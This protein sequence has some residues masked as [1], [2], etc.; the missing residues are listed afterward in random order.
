MPPQAPTYST[1]EQMYFTQLGV[2]LMRMEG[3]G[4]PYTSSTKPGDKS[5]DRIRKLTLHTYHPSGRWVEAFPTSSE[6]ATQV[7]ETLLQSIIPRFGLL[8]YNLT[9]VLPLFLKL[10]NRFPKS[11]GIKLQLHIPYRPQS[12]GKVE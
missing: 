7:A 1:Q 3:L 12:S 4:P 5:L 2:S 6:K 8:L 10:L 9:M 11:L